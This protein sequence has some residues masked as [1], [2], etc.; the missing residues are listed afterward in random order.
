MTIGQ[1]LKQLREQ[2]GL[3][4]EVVAKHLGVATQTIFKY[5]KEIVTNIPAANIEKLATLFGVSPSSLLGWD[6]I[7]NIIPVTMRSY[8]LLGDI[9][10]GKPIVADRKYDAFAAAGFEDTVSFALRC[11]GDSMINARIFDGDIVFIRE[12]DMVANGEIAAVVVGEEATLKRVY[13]YPHEQKMILVSENP[14]YPPL[15]YQ[16]AALDEIRILGKAVAFQS[17]I[18]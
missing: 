5:E 17:E 11:K 18:R 4:Q 12:Q 2:K 13:Y 9:A 15:S 16:G 6:N 10:C 14:A 8:P 7:P 3:T 1:K